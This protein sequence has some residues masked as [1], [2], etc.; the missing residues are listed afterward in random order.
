MKAHLPQ[1]E[2]EKE[3]AVGLKR[4]LSFKIRSEA[5][6]LRKAGKEI[7]KRVR[8]VINNDPLLSLIFSLINT[9]HHQIHFPPFLRFNP[10]SLI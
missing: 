5:K 6:S 2:A 1:G 10:I 8:I 7:K 4:K 3:E 9:H